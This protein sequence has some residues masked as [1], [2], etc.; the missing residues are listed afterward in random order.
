[1]PS[2]RDIIA[3]KAPYRKLDKRAMVCID[4]ANWRPYLSQARCGI[5]WTEFQALMR[6][7]YADVSFHYY[8]GM[9]TKDYYL[10]HNSNA[11]IVDFRRAKKARENYYK[12]LRK[13]GFRVV[14]KPISAIRKSPTRFK[15]KC[16]FDVEISVD[17]L[18]RLE[19]YDIFVLCS[20]DG[21]FV[22]LLRRLKHRLKETYIIAARGR[23]NHD[24]I[25]AANRYDY[26]DSLV[27]WWHGLANK[28]P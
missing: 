10:Q 19:D 11:T 8:D 5:V 12:Q 24:L 1:M 14:T 26:L 6:S 13:L 2:I 16:N 22:Y 25:H 4:F 17:A 28:R 7:L 9:L 15:F 27:F 18:E 20:G 21:D 23:V 3:G